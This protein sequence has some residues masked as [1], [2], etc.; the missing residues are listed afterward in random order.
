M[1]SHACRVDRSTLRARRLESCGG[2]NQLDALPDRSLLSRQGARCW[3][4]RRMQLLKGEH[5]SSTC[6]SGHVPRDHLGVEGIPSGDR[7]D[8]EAYSA[9][10][11][12]ELHRL[13]HDCCV[14]RRG[15]RDRVLLL[16][17]PQG[18]DRTRLQFSVHNTCPERI[19]NAHL[20][21]R[22]HGGRRQLRTAVRMHTPVRCV[23]VEKQFPTGYKFRQPVARV[24]ESVLH[25]SES[26]RRFI[27]SRSRHGALSG[28]GE[29]SQC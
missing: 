18:H 26:T 29:G 12:E 13:E 21:L 10:R 15:P 28:E 22:L 2:L 9:A 25:Y 3:C 16:D 4:N 7:E 27:T 6:L 19:E 14:P 20:I 1:Q 17:L 8:G 23:V 24:A 11:F 5:L